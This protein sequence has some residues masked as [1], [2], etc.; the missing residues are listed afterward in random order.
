MEIVDPVQQR[1]IAVR[2]FQAQ[3]AAAGLQNAVGLG[4][5]LINVGHV[6]DAESNRIGVECA[7]FE[8]E[9]FGVAFNHIDHRT[10][11]GFVDAALPDIEHFAADITDGRAAAFPASFDDAHRDITSTARNVDMPKCPV[12]F[13]RPHLRDQIIFPEPVQA[14]RHQIIHQVVA[15]GHAGEDLINQPLPL[16]DTN[17]SKTE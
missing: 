13:R 7:A 9:C 4:E 1:H 8:W 6:A 12:R 15:A 16:R 5:R 14:T 17:R 2:K 10:E 3:K 11:A